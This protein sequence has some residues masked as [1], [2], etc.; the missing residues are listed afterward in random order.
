[1]TNAAMDLRETALGQAELHRKDG[2]TRPI[3]QRRKRVLDAINHRNPDRVPID[4]G[5]SAVTGVHVSC[6]AKL[7]EHYGLEKRLVK[8][9]EPYQMLGLVE[10]DLK[11]AV[12]VD[13]TP[14]MS[15]TNMFGFANRG[16][17][18]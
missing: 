10:D 14:L 2:A 3:G 17:R 1:M 5:G 18:P 13:V 9:C 12:G 6:V 7:R 8:V 16:W 15:R 11:E 4:F